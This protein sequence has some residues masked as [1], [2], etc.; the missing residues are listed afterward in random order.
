M[1]TLLPSHSNLFRRVWVGLIPWA[2]QLLYLPLNRLQSGGV[3]PALPVDALIPLSPLWVIP[4]VLTLVTWIIIPIWAAL[5]LDDAAYR[6]F[7]LAELICVVTGITTFFLYPT[8]IIRPE[9]PSTEGSLALVARLYASDQAY[10]ALPSGHAYLSGLYMLV[11]SRFCPRWRALWIAAYAI[12]LL[13]T[14]FTRQHY[15]LDLLAGFALALAA[16][17][18]AFLAVKTR[19]PQA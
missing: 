16:Y 19:L 13:S 10:N 17:C 8:Y 14:L 18:I 4:Y 7:I 9:L 12:I 6:A 5:K 11:L 2:I 1:Q 3:A 15:V